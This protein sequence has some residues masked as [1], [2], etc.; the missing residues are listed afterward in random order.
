MEVLKDRQGAIT[1]EHLNDEKFKEDAE[2]LFRTGVISVI[3]RCAMIYIPIFVFI[4]GIF[5]Q[6]AD[7]YFSQLNDDLK[8]VIQKQHEISSIQKQSKVEIQSIRDRINLL[9]KVVYKLE[10]RFYRDA[11]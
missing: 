9:D 3:R 4:G 7:S 1:W 8:T 10:D 6:I 5:L 2:R 11:K